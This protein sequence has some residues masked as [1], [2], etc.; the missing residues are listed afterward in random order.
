MAAHQHN[1]I[2][3]WTVEA[4]GA[5]FSRTK[6]SLNEELDTTD[7]TDDAPVSAGDVRLEHRPTSRVSPDRAESSDSIMQQGTSINYLCCVY[8]DLKLMGTWFLFE[9]I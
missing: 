3:I 2:L 7:R 5:G 4:E 6:Y 9:E 8:S 1:L